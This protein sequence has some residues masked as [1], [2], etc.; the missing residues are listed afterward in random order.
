MIPQE[1]EEIYQKRLVLAGYLALFFFWIILV[2]LFYLQIL[3]HDY[4]WKLA[5]QR[6]F[7]RVPIPAPRGRIFDRRGVLLAG[8]RPSFNLYLDPFYLKG[9]EDQVLRSL[10]QILGEDFPKL[11]TEYILKKREA[12]GEVLFRRGLDWEKVAR[13][14]ARRYYL[15]GVRV[16]ARPERFYP[17]GASFFHLLGYVSPISK[18]DL[19]KLKEE[20]YGPED[21]LGR[22]GLERAYETEL[23]GLKG[24]RELERDAFGRTVKIVSE[25]PPRPGKDLFL[26]VDGLFQQETYG[27]LE[28]RSGAIVVMDPRRGAL[29]ALVSAPAPDPAGFIKGFSPRAWRAL[30]ADPY[31]PLLNKALLAY[32]PGSTFKPVTLLAALEAGLISP[33]EEIYC[34]G[35]YRLG[36]RI[37]HCWRKW[38]HGKV[39]LI[40][41]LA[42]SCDTYFYVLGERLDIDYLAQYARRCGFG[43]PSGLGLPGENPGLVPDRRWKRS[44]FGERW[45]KGENLVVAIGQ[46]PLE[47]NLVQLVKFYA[48]L[49]N[50]GHLLKPYVVSE[51]SEPSGKKIKIFSPE[52]EGQLPASGANLRWVVRG[53]IEAVNGKR[54]TGKAAKM[55]DILVAGKTGTAQVVKKSKDKK[56]DQEV[57]YE[58]RD[59]A[60]FIAFA[61]ARDPEIV[62]GV[63]VE[64]GGHGGEAAAPIAAKVLRLYF[65]GERP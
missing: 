54:G 56:K 21:F 16:E 52:E 65:Q 50:G 53:L 26:T 57:P 29:L 27:L 6:T 10:A 25:V 49:G 43:R 44:V 64:H 19:K 38:G 14:E 35:F 33:E 63:L 51:I 62:V 30:T 60:W 18:K 22:T 42:Q 37:F 39:F 61:P 34:P 45:Q 23:R 59:H 1:T 13:L 7:V 58:K 47:V 9:K 31:H 41:A 20:G 28:G 4:F 11:K 12:Y 3:K 46:G 2:K 32:H 24:E 8:D 17:F 36:R 48:A 55:K 40:Q 15:P 5:R